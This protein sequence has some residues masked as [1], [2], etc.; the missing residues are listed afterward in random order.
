MR[1]KEKRIN[2]RRKQWEK[3]LVSF[4]LRKNIDFNTITKNF[5]FH[6]FTRFAH[7]AADVQ[8][9]VLCIAFTSLGCLAWWM[10]LFSTL[11]LTAMKINDKTTS[12][13]IR[14]NTFL[15]RSSILNGWKTN[16]TNIKKKRSFEVTKLSVVSYKTRTK[17]KIANWCQLPIELWQHFGWC[18]EKQR[19]RKKITRVT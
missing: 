19:K 9:I 17:K 8:K 10:R 7:F 3:K 5:F 6:H 18:E 15:Q 2:E 4:E 16:V 11:L 14:V 13:G 12:Y 1:T